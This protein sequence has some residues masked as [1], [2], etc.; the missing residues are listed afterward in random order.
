MCGLWLVWYMDAWMTA[1]FD[2]RQGTGSCLHTP[3]S[4]IVWV[5]LQKTVTMSAEIQEAIGIKCEPPTLPND[6]AEETGTLLLT[7]V[8]EEPPSLPRFK[9][10]ASDKDSTTTR[11]KAKKSV[12]NSP[13]KK[14]NVKAEPSAPRKKRVN[15]NRPVRAKKE[16][17]K[18]GGASTCNSEEVKQYTCSVCNKSYLQA[19]SLLTHMRLHTGERP[20]SCKDCGKTFIQSGHLTS[21]MRRHTGVRAHACDVCGKRFG[22]A[23]DLKVK[24]VLEGVQLLVVT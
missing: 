13:A 10:N 22:A 21:H 20:F 11:K 18:S 14:C 3:F 19:S 24:K 1:R 5:F 6:D 16:A 12:D 9:A 17:V 8:C 15:V 2:G 4:Y 7:A 23:G